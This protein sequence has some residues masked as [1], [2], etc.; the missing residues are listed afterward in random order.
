MDANSVRANSL[1]FNIQKTCGAGNCADG[2]QSIH[3]A[4]ANRMHEDVGPLAPG[5]DCDP[6]NYQQE[7]LMKDREIK[8]INEHKARRQQVCSSV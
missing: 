3:T 5:T 2:D 8:Q 6:P 1:S 4:L 7:V